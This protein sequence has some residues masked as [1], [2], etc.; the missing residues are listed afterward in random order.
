[1]SRATP[2]PFITVTICTRDRST[3]I[4]DVLETLR[5]NTYPDFR[6]LVVDQS[7]DSATY[8]VVQHFQSIWSRLDYLHVPT[9]GLSLAR[10]LAI[11]ASTGSI[12][13]FTDDDCLVS[14]TWVAQIAEAFVA[15]PA[16]AV[17]FGRV[18]PAQGLGK[19]QIPVAIQPSRTPRTLVGLPNPLSV[20]LFTLG[21]GNSMAFRRSSLAV[22]GPFDERF[23]AGSSL[24][25]GEDVDYIYR[26]LAAGFKVAYKPAILNYHRMWRSPEQVD[27]LYLRTH[28]S[29]GALIAKHLLL[30][31]PG[32][33]WYA[34]SRFWYFIVR[35]ALHGVV[36]A[37]PRRI[38]P[39]IVA[40]VATIRGMRHYMHVYRYQALQERPTHE[41]A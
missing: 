24:N 5:G 22:I 3:Q 6:V 38:R 25:G 28:I 15:D 23:G 8:A 7:Q 9:T 2:P 16:L 26:A 20:N 30:K 34:L 18:L 13:A 21:V 4:G 36:S 10:N 41:H 33:H 12:I 11:R 29:A 39:S 17:L 37:N 40:A 14:N 35:P 31:T 19:D 1:M 32:A 27:T